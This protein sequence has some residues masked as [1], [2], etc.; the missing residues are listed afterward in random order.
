[1]GRKEKPISE[2]VS[3]IVSKVLPLPGGQRSNVTNL[4][5]SDWPVWRMVPYQGHILGHWALQVGNSTATWARS[6]FVSGRDAVG[7]IQSSSYHDYCIHISIV[8]ALAWPMLLTWRLHVSSS[9]PCLSTCLC[10]FLLHPTMITVFIH[11]L[12]WRWHG[13]CC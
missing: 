11:P 5:P 10:P 13:Q 8:L 1:M 7:T 6:A 2:Y 12:Y 9:F 3:A 4:L